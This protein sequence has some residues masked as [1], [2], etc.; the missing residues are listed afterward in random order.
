[1]LRTLMTA[2]LTLVALAPTDLHG[3][4]ARPS[5][6]DVKRSND[7]QRQAADDAATI[8]ARGPPP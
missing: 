7:Q 2:V 8:V 4:A 6:V 1:M 5:F 3:Q